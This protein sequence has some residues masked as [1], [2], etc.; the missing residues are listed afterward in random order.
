MLN[1]TELQAMLDETFA[2][3]EFQ[4][5]DAAFDEAWGK[6]EELTQGATDKLMD[7]SGG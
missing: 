6:L 3:V 5:E 7:I 1:T 2:E 4:M